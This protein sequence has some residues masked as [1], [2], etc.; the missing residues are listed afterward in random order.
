MADTP[1]LQNTLETFAEYGVVWHRP[2]LFNPQKTPVPFQGFSL[3]LCQLSPEGLTALLYQS[4]WGREWTPCYEMLV[5]HP[6]GIAIQVTA[7]RC[8]HGYLPFMLVRERSGALH[9]FCVLCSGNWALSLSPQGEVVFSQTPEM[10]SGTMGA[11]E[12]LP[13]PQTLH[14]QDD[15]DSQALFH[16]LQAFLKAHILPESRLPAGLVE[17]NHWWRYEDEDITEDV[18]LQNAKAAATLGVNLVTLDAGWFGDPDSP[19]HWTQC[20]GDWKTVNTHRFPHGLQYLADAVHGMG[21]RFGLWMEP[22]ALGVKSVL[23]SAHPEWEARRNGKPLPEPYLCLGAD[24]AAERMYGELCRLVDVTG[25]DWLKLDFNVNPG[26]GCNR[27]DHG[28]AAGMGLYRHYEA[29]YAALDKVRAKYPGLILENCSSGGLRMDLEM[30][31]HTDVTFLSDPDETPHS[32]QCFWAASQFFPADRLLHW[33]WSETRTLPD[34]SHVFPSFSITTDTPE[35][36]VRYTLRAAMLHR[37]GLCRDLTALTPAMQ[38]LFAQEIALYKTRIAP[39]MEEGIL[40][41]LTGQPLRSHA[42]LDD[43][44]NPPPNS[45]FCGIAG[46][47]AAFQYHTEKQGMVLCFVLEPLTSTVR[48]PLM[49]LEP[50]SVY[51]FTNPDTGYRSTALGRELL[52]HGLSVAAGEAQRC[53]CWFLARC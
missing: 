39:L 44:R 2:T 42:R 11:G 52:T 31:R 28:H 19:V 18:F 21:M 48:I 9:A 8:G 50:S 13:L 1:V 36:A 4:D 30:L 51:S 33:A 10:L 20:R 45:Q 6:Q 23:L 3:P 53:V 34:G 12:T 27:A 25:C 35:H 49:G 17:W 46:E 47:V 24:G 32:L 26:Y 15:Y 22:E 41:R 40:F 16:R 7:G 38:T 43:F 29:Y 37:F 14:A 5:N